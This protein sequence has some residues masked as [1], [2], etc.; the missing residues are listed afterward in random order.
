LALPGCSG[1]RTE[2]PIW[3]G[4]V[5]PL[6]GPDRVAGE[7]MKRGMML[8]IEEVNAEDQRIAGRRLAIIHADSRSQP[9]RA[10][11]EAV[12]LVTLNKLAALVGGRDQATADRLAQALQ[13]YNPPLFTPACLVSTNPENVF[14]LDVTPDF[15]GAKLAQFAAEQFGA[16]RAALLVDESLPACAAI[17]SAFAREWRSTADRQVQSL[18]IKGTEMPSR[19]PER[20]KKADAQVLVVA[21]TADRVSDIWHTLSGQNQKIQFVFAGEAAQWQRIET[22]PELR[23]KVHGVTV[24]A[25]G[26]FEEMGQQFLAHYR[27][28]YKEDADVDAMRGYELIHVLAEG[29]RKSRGIGGL[30]LREAMGEKEDWA[31]LTGKL[32]FKNGS[33][34]RPLFAVRAGDTVPLKTFDP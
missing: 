26:R 9:D 6:S 33:A 2:E 21:A 10:R 15:R 3:I 18:E 31:G 25:A 5:G 20:L 4:H 13:P 14:S 27:K 22:D 17:A 1:R 28:Q 19:L 34:L 8:A 30:I 23:G 24:Y 7:S 32:R 29:L 12:R 16:T 11:S